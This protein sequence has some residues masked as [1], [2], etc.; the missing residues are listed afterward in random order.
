[1]SAVKVLTG[2]LAQ[3]MTLESNN[4]GYRNTVSVSSSKRQQVWDTVWSN[5]DSNRFYVPGNSTFST[6]VELP[7]D[8]VSVAARV[9]QFAADSA[10]GVPYSKKQT[11]ITAIRITSDS[12]TNGL[13]A[14]TPSWAANV[15]WHMDQ[16]G[17]DLAWQATTSEARVVGAYKM[18]TQS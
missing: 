18:A 6:V 1:I 9:V 13:V 17:L 2:D 11:S 10:P 15:Y 5:S 4:D 8:V 3:S 14:A 12:A 7:D 16:R